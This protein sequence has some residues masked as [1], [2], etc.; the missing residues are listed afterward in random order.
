MTTDLRDLL[1]ELVADQP[2]HRIDLDARIATARRRSRRRTTATV[3]AVSLA[4]AAAITVG[5]NLTPRATLDGTPDPAAR[6]TAA[7]P[8]SPVP[9]I[10]K[11]VPVQPSNQRRT[12][13]SQALADQLA[14][15]APEIAAT[16]GGSSHSYQ[17]IALNGYAL[18]FLNADVWWRYPMGDLT[19]SV[20]VSVQVWSSSDPTQ[21]G[22]P[23]C[24]GTGVN[25]CDL[26]RQRP[27]GS[28]VYRR[29][30]ELYG[31]HNHDAWVKHPDGTIVHVGSDAEMVPGGHN[32]LLDGE[33]TLEVAEAITV[34]P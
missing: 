5:L 30:Y 14:Q 28:T 3:T 17:N 2:E 24:H 31:A 7:S 6:P 34:R 21:H 10:I 11:G 9:T 19:N 33:R 13:R 20:V 25:R 16:A 26:V 23:V 4:T 15:V 29:D 8:T 12:A 27:D 18:P 1:T 32:T 22:L